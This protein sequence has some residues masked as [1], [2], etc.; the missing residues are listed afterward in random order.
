MT[1]TEL[2]I[3]RRLISEGN[4]RLRMES[5]GTSNNS[6][7]NNS[8]SGIQGNT[9]KIKLWRILEKYGVWQQY[10]HG[11]W[12]KEYRDGLFREIQDLFQNK[13]NKDQQLDKDH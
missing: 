2:L 9:L 3:K 6:S 13:G 12:K 5:G 4:D 10:K 1:F 11:Y 8:R 7:I